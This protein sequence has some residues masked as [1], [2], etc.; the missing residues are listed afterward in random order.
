MLKHPLQPLGK[1]SKTHGFSGDLVLVSDRMLDDELEN[2][3]ELFVIIDGL[4][5]PFPVEEFTLRTDS[6]AQIKLEFIG[7]SDEASELVGCEVCADVSYSEQEPGLEQWTGFTV[8]DAR[9]GEIGVIGQIEDFNGNIVLQ[10]LQDD[11]E[12][13]ISLFPELVTGI[14]D[15]ARILYIALPDGYF[16]N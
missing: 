1:F 8:R 5:V 11:R 3:D 6:S 16:D 14:D 13:L 12:T 4:P 15:D 2:L 10:V 7:S 9:Y